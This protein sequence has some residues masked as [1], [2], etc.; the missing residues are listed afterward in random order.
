MISSDPQ[1]GTKQGYLIQD[2]T[3]CL[4]NLELHTIPLILF[5]FQNR[6]VAL[7]QYYQG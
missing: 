3:Q 7:N 4:W 1:D 6:I 2:R 5:T